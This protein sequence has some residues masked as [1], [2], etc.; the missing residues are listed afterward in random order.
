MVKVV[1]QLLQHTIGGSGRHR[2]R[3]LGLDGGIFE[4]DVMKDSNKVMAR[5]G[6]VEQI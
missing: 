1:L 5:W 3:A 6:R 4:I 2:S